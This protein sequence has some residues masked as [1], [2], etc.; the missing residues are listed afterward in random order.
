MADKPI[1][2]SDYLAQ[3]AQ[4]AKVT[5]RGAASTAGPIYQFHKSAQAQHGTG[6][7]LSWLIDILTRPLSG[8]TNAIQS[9]VDA[10]VNAQKRGSIDFGESISSLP[11][12]AFLTG[13]LSTDPEKH[14]TFSDV[15]E[16]STD[17]FG[18]L[19][20]KYVDVPNNVEP[21]LK[22]GVGLALD[23]VGDPLMWIPGAQIAKAG[24]L[25]ARG[26]KAVLGGVSALKGTIT[27]TR[28]TEDA[29]KVAESAA[30]AGAKVEKPTPAGAA[31]NELIDNPELRAR[32]LQ[33]PKVRARYEGVLAEAS[34]REL[35]AKAESLAGKDMSRVLSLFTKRPVKTP[36]PRRFEKLPQTAG[37]TKPIPWEGVGAEMGKGA[38]KEG[39][40][41]V[42]GDSWLGSAVKQIEK[43]PGF[44]QRNPGFAAAVTK[45]AEGDPRAIDSLR[46][47]YT[48]TYLP[49]F[50][51]A[52]QQGKWV[53]SLGRE[54]EF[55]PKLPEPAKML[56]GLQAFKAAKVDH[57]ANIQATLGPRLMKTLN[58][59]SN[60]AKFDSAV[61]ELRGVLAESI[62]VPEMRRLTAPVKGMLEQLGIRIDSIP[63]GV[64]RP[65]AVVN[66][67][68]VPKTVEEQLAKMVGPETDPEVM[69]V[70]T[71]GM[72]TA[73]GEDLIKRN[74][75]TTHPHRTKTGVYRTEDQFGAGTGRILKQANTYFQWNLA[76]SAISHFSKLAS[77]SK[78]FGYRRAEFVSE[79]VRES[80]RLEER[81]FDQ[82]GVPFVTGV[83]DQV[84]PLSQSQVWDTLHLLDAR[85]TYRTIWNGGTAVAPTN[86]LDAAYIA[87][88]GGDRELIEK[89]I[90]NT[91]TRYNSDGRLEN[92]PNGIVKGGRIGPE[93]LNGDQLVGSLTD[94]I[95]A[96]TPR[97]TQ[98][99]AYNTESYAS[100]ALAET[101]MLADNVLSDIEAL[102]GAK[103]GFGDLLK[104]IDNAGTRLGKVAED[105]GT[106]QDA[107]NRA[108][109]L[110]KTVLPAEDQAIAKTAVGGERILTDTKT[111]VAVAEK[112][113]AANAQQGFEEQ[114][115]ITMADEPFDPSGAARDL[116]AHFEAENATGILSKVQ[117][118][119]SRTG[120]M[121]KEMAHELRK[122]ENIYSYLIGNYSHR[123]NKLARTGL[124]P[125]ALAALLRNA[126]NGATVP[127]QEAVVAELADLW[128]RMF[129]VGEKQG[130]LI[131][132]AFF[133]NGNNLEHVNAML[134]RADLPAGLRFDMEAGN[135][136]AKA[137]GTTLF[138]ELAKQPE[139]WELDDPIGQLYGLY[140][141]FTDLQVQQTIAQSFLKSVKDIP[142]AISHAPKSGFSRVVNDSGRSIFAKYL[143]D[144][145]YIEDNVLDSMHQIDNLMQQTMEL[146]GPLGK[147]IRETY[148]PFLQAWKYGMTL[149]N[150]TH[151]VRNFISDGTLQFLSLGARDFAKS[152]KDAFQALA[153]R[154]AYDGFSAQRALQVIE[155]S[156]ELPH[157]GDVIIK[158]SRPGFELTANG[159]YTAAADRGN[160]MSYITLEQLNVA[161]DA[162]EGTGALARLWSKASHSRP[163]EAIGSVSQARD[164]ISRLS[165]FS[166]FV[167]QNIDN[168]K[169]KTFDELLDAASW[170]TRK[171]HPDGTDMTR[172]EQYFRLIIPFY[173]WQRKAIPLVLESL[174][175]HPA[176][177]MVFPKAQYNLAVAMGLNP[178]SLSDPFP[179]DQLFPSYLTNQING[180]QFALDGQYYG[181]NPGFASNDILNDYLQ[182]EWWRSVLGS[183]SPFIR[184]PFELAAGGNVGTGAKIND[185]SDFVDQQIPGVGQ[186]SRITGDS[187]TGSLVS[188]LQGG[189]ID[190]QFQVAAGNKKPE[191]SALNWL[192]G[193]GI[194]PMSQPNQINYAEIEKRNRESQQRGF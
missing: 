183:T 80:V 47:W 133:R 138:E 58:Q 126:R 25:I 124:T 157:V 55:V 59:Y 11:P 39:G 143:P 10:S 6:D 151:H 16:Q 101:G 60:P 111:P 67:A 187:V 156:E 97:L 41:I 13:L 109:V 43:E 7:P 26:G 155:A 42:S 121:T 81:G 118:V 24:S 86:L 145:V 23:I 191:V 158:G 178:D 166:Q 188:M 12:I 114:V 88:K 51:Q 186:A 40:R 78:R 79:K 174:L 154:D 167:R 30:R 193:L 150:P 119:F 53:D 27:G 5:P 44:A 33:D 46:S 149:P 169:Y 115:K 72:S 38:R 161:G 131:D 14:R 34:R 177:V 117:P 194:T 162:S 184:A 31:L 36:T 82:L 190:Q 179:T 175:T 104:A 70:A 87:V 8:V 49:R 123:L 137:N 106:T 9:S 76:K 74:V 64:R 153:T 32:A 28:A 52:R 182:P 110:V 66:T 189:G 100:R 73:A 172:A 21:A 99:V 163:A 132:N 152:Q 22:G 17:K 90:R 57:E 159:L 20:S 77:D 18:S 1:S 171:W 71:R 102:Y 122:D 83:G 141:A 108:S 148:Q 2:A 105:F 29:A 180:P 91:K 98:L 185:Y 107:L 176:R 142:G 62:D 48:N 50:A 19:D 84:V 125:V 127:S 116:G 128:G 168:P 134:D 61:S 181:I 3:A 69:T 164:H 130:A 68:P 147:F 170:Q 136:A 192:L 103:N 140:K 139:H 160:L 4:Q 89:A 37:E 112:D 165:H 54:A 93:Q 96:A 15:I 65:Q 75:K 94:L 56:D 95:V 45:A 92:L 120:G 85:T 63:T 135:T 173:S 113:A 35:G 129:G 144:D 146:K